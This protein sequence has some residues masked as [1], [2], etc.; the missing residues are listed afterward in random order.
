M[1]KGSSRFARTP[2]LYFPLA[3]V[4]YLAQSSLCSVM[5]QS[6]VTQNVTNQN[7]CWH[8]PDFLL[9]CCCPALCSGKLK[10]T[11][12]EDCHEWIITPPKNKEPESRSFTST[13]IHTPYG[14]LQLKQ[15][16]ISNSVYAPLLNLLL[17]TQ[18]LRCDTRSPLCSIS[19]KRHYRS[20][21]CALLS[22][23]DYFEGCRD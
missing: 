22:A 5:F 4:A 17:E 12:N 9:G 23:R 13:S 19:V 18:M 20:R 8:L 16:Q 14:E 6:L 7:L 2:S 3:L 11:D 1:F 15:W 21:Q 10:S